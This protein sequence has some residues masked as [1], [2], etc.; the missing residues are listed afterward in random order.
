MYLGVAAAIGVATRLPALQRQV[1]ELHDSTAR[2][3]GLKTLAEYAHTAALEKARSQQDDAGQG[4]P[5][6]QDKKEKQ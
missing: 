3:Y 4:T 6:D 2:A 1:L 5:A